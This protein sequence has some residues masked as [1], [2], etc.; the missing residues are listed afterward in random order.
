MREKRKPYL[1]PHFYL[2]QKYNEISVNYVE[3]YHDN[4]SNRSNQKQS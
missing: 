3:S 1:F 2:R 4:D